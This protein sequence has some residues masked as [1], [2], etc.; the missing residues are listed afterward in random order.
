MVKLLDNRMNGLN[1]W[2][3]SL[4]GLLRPGAFTQTI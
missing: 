4:Y 1:Y 3:M 2:E